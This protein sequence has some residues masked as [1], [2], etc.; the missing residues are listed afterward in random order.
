MAE[1][2]SKGGQKHWEE[3]QFEIKNHS[4]GKGKKINSRN[5]VV[6]HEGGG[7]ELQTFLGGNRRGPTEFTGAGRKKK[8]AEITPL[9]EIGS[10]TWIDRRKVRSGWK[11]YKKGSSVE[12]RRVF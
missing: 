8:P 2:Q 1:A 4:F 12:K 10:R 6:L 5:L 11:K 3:G 7:G 9:E